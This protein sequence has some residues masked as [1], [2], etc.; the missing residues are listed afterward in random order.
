VN[1]CLIQFGHSSLPF[2]GVNN[3]GIGKSGG[4]FG[5][6]EFSHSKAVLVQKTNA[7]RFFYPPYTF[8]TKWLIE[9]VLKWF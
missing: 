1:D 6:Q 7:L 2:G 3:S 5:F 8:R 4:K 9:Q